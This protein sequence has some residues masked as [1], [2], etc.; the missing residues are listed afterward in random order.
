MAHGPDTEIAIARINTWIQK[1]NVRAT[2]FLSKIN[3]T[4]LPPIPDT[5]ECLDTGYTRI[6]SYRRLPRNLVNFSCNDTPLEVL[7]EL[8]ETLKFINCGRTSLKKLPKLPTL[9]ALY[10]FKTQIKELPELPEGLV[11]VSVWGTSIT[12]LPTIPLSLVWLQISETPIRCLPDLAR[13]S[14]IYTSKCHELLIH[15]EKEESIY[16]YNERWAVLR[17]R[18]RCVQRARLWKEGIIAAV[19]HPRNVERWLEIGGWPLIAMIS[20]DDGLM[21]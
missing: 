14:N 5:V 16:E 6:K 19:W 12:S 8:P 17:D 13:L 11:G 10:C 15:Q 4:S 7:P 9:H 3:I 20:G 2:L 18:N 1:G 21:V